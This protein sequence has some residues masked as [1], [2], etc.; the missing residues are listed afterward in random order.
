MINIKNLFKIL[1]SFI[2][3]LSFIVACVPINE[4][5]SI[6]HPFGTNSFWALKIRG[7]TETPVQVPAVYIGSG[8]NVVAYKA[9]D[10]GISDS[11]VYRAIDAFDQKIAP[12]EHSV[13]GPPSDVDSDNKVTLLFL[14]IDDGYT[15]GSSY[16]AGYFN[17]IDLYS[18][19]SA[20]SQLKRHSN[21]RE[22]MYIDT[23]PADV[24]SADLLGTIAHEYQHL[25]H[26]N[27][28]RKYN[29]SEDTWVNE[30]LSELASDI[31]GY[32]P[33]SSRLNYFWNT[34]LDSL[35]GWDG[36][37][38]DYSHV[39]VYFRYLA[40]IFG[41]SI[42]SDIFNDPYAGVESVNRIIQS[43]ADADF[44]S[45]CG[46]HLPSGYEYFD[47]SYRYFLGNLIGADSGKSGTDGN[48]FT[49]NILPK[50]Q[51]QHTPVLPAAGS[52]GATILY[53]YS[54]LLKNGSNPGLSG[55][56]NFTILYKSGDSRFIVYNYSA[57]NLSSGTVTASSI[58]PNIISSYDSPVELSSEKKSIHYHVQIDEE[59]LK[60]L[61]PVK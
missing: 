60:N 23:F 18:D 50:F 9:I 26:Y 34:D 27:H 20:Y 14:D 32:G 28:M 8:S 49:I 2:I 5:D 22:M 48:T 47:C 38:W 7:N 33:Q 54:Y 21:E 17:P 1:F 39:Y 52:A 51:M 31:T 55:S 56:T 4:D 53:P 16:I 29:Y 19:E 43:H 58:Q 57:S 24:T 59:S 12:K 25:L 15:P 61:K 40:D 46:N 36:Q 42:L 3:I 37:L 30:G 45:N 11:I 13:Y 41:E 44:L 10:A 35:I 6:E